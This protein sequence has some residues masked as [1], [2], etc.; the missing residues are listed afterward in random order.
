VGSGGILATTNGGA[1]W[2]LQPSGGGKT[3]L[4]VTFP[5]GIH[6]WAVGSLGTILVTK[7]GGFPPA[8]TT[9]PR[10]TK[11]EPASAKRGALVSIAGVN[12]G[13]VRGVSVVKFG[14]KTC[15][16]Y[17][18]WSDGQITCKVPRQAKYGTVKIAVTTPAG[19]SNAVRFKVKR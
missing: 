18:S 14:L 15:T 12:F 3:L 19:R 5:D 4:G 17:L 11:R 2:A 10:I 1:T 16:A 9:P 8:P 13:A 7:S 6:G